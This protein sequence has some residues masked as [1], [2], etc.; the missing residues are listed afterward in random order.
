MIGIK[1]SIPK[2][3]TDPSIRSKGPIFTLNCHQHLLGSV[4]R[5]F[6]LFTGEYPEDPLSYQIDPSYHPLFSWPPP[7]AKTFKK[8][9]LEVLERKPNLG[10]YCPH[11]YKLW[12]KFTLRPMIR[13]FFESSS[14]F[15]FLLTG[16]GTL[17]IVSS[18]LVC[19]ARSNI[20]YK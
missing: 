10:I 13:G 17:P 14:A 8:A 1:E 15:S 12:W 20:L 7:P 3:L 4:W 11:L 2:T 5:L 18:V 9:I 19:D 6:V 16:R